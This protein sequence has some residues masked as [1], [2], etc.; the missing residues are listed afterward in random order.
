MSKKY[1]KGFS[2]FGFLPVTLNE[3]GG[4]TVD[5]SKYTAVPGGKSC[6]P[7]DNKT[8]YSIPADDGVWDSGSDWTDTTLVVTFTEMDLDTLSSITGAKFD[9]E[10]DK[11]MDEGTLDEAPEVAPTF[12]ALRRDGGYRLYRYYAARCTGYKVSHTTKGENNDAQSYELTFKCVPRKSDNLIR[13]TK[14]VEKGDSLAWIKKFAIAESQ[15]S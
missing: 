11:I 3:V 1:L 9:K 15:T 13:S 4:Y 7:T 2:N 6:S 10:T 12:S 5:D 8:D 14:D